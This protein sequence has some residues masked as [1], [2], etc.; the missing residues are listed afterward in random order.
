M[1]KRRLILWIMAVGVAT[2]LVYFPALDAP[3]HFD[4]EAGILKNPALWDITDIVDVVTFKPDLPRPVFNVSLAFDASLHGLEP[5]GFHLTNLVIH[6][7]CALL[8]WWMAV[9]VLGAAGRETSTRNMAGIAAGLIFA[10]HPAATETVVYIWSRSTGLM[11]PFLLA[12]AAL[13]IRGARRRG[14]ALLIASLFCY[15]LAM[16]TK[17]E[18]S[19]FPVFLVALEAA[20]FDRTRRRWRLKWILPYWILPVLLLVLRWLVAGE[21]LD[22]VSWRA[23]KGDEMAWLAHHR[24]IWSLVPLQFLTECKVFA[25]YIGKFIRPI[26]LSVDYGVA[27][28]SGFPSAPAV[29]GAL[30]VVAVV[31]AFFSLRKRLPEAAVAAALLLLPVA[32]FFV[33]PVSDL[34][35]DRRMYLPLA[36]FSILVGR[37]FASLHVRREKFAKVALVAMLACLGMLAGNRVRVWGNNVRLW[38]SAV[39]VSP[40]KLRPRAVLA[41]YLYESGFLERAV[42]QNRMLMRMDPLYTTPIVNLGLLYMRDG[43]L[44]VAERYFSEAARIHPGADFTAHYN[45]GVVYEKM[46]RL[47]EAGEQYRKALHINPM[48]ATSNFKLGLIEASRGDVVSSVGYFRKALEINPYLVEAR[49][50][51]GS[52]LMD[53]GRKKEG[54]MHLERAARDAPE[55]PLVLYNLGMGCLEMGKVAEAR[56]VLSRSASMGFIRAYFG[57]AMVERA[58]GDVSGMC[59]ALNVFLKKAGSSGDKSILRLTAEASEMY[60]S[61]CR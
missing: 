12:S 1:N 61:N 8:V 4:D 5:R 50:N 36:G 34:M 24:G 29:L 17:E 26:N 42:S 16:G 18:A 28:E 33:M 44:E 45:L 21:S 54:L 23:G 58:G 60:G 40:E 27:L 14:K 55:N 57:L 3:F 2:I 59:N 32:V 25:A 6:F 39:K 10:V 41:R 43:D 22:F 7:L 46:G 11:A 9:E 47:E 30:L 56:Q 20:L 48:M 19:F 15:A 35:V 31:A 53:I 52:V 49:M 37:M 51:L 38:T 13:W